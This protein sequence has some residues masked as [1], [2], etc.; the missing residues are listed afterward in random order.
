MSVH[1]AGLQ[2]ASDVYVATNLSAPCMAEAVEPGF[3][4]AGKSFA[5]YAHAG[6]L[7]LDHLADLADDAARSEVRAHA[8]QLGRALGTAVEETESN[9]R[10]LLKQHKTE[11]EN[12]M[13]SLGGCSFLAERRSGEL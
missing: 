6:F 13:D 2:E 1:A 9:L 7:H 4:H 12:F 11:W 8:F 3:R 10:D 5:E